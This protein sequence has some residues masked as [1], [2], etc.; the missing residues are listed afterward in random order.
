[1][2]V[3]SI[4]VVSRVSNKAFLFLN[5]ELFPLLVE[6]LELL[7]LTQLGVREAVSNAVIRSFWQETVYK[8]I[9]HVVVCK[10]SFRRVTVSFLVHSVDSYEV[11]AQAQL[12]V[13]F[14]ARK[15]LDELAT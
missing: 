13:H 6:L 8:G 12:L 7:I 14:L 15:S 10:A 11:V 2:I 4:I 5:G 3:R 9:P 1:M